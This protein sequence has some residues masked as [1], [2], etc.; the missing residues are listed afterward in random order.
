MVRRGVV[1]IWAVA[2]VILLVLLVCNAEAEDE[3][4]KF[5]VRQ[6]ASG[7]NVIGVL[8]QPIG[9]RLVVEGEAPASHFKQGNELAVSTVNGVALPSAVNIEINRRSL[10]ILSGIRYK[11]EGYETGSFE[12]APDWLPPP[13]PQLVF[14]WRSRFA[15]FRVIEP[16]GLSLDVLDSEDESVREAARC[17]RER[18]A[19]LA[20][21]SATE[22]S[23]LVCIG[24]MMERFPY[25]ASEALERTGSSRRNLKSFQEREG[26]FLI[27]EGNILYAAGLDVLGT[28][29]AVS[30]LQSRLRARDGKVWF[31]FPEW[32]EGGHGVLFEKPAIE[33]R[34]EYLN[35]GYNIPGI[36]PHEWDDA[37]WRQYIDRLVLAKLNRLYLYL[38]NDTYSVYPGSAL[39]KVALNR[40]LHE[41]IRSAIAYA[42]TRGLGVTYMMCPTFFPRDVWEAHPELHA[43]IEYVKHGFP[44]VCPQAPGA[45]DLMKDIARSEMEWFKG[46][47][48][49][50]I[51]FYDPGGC[52][53]EKYGCKSKQ[54]EILARQVVEFSGLFRALNPSAR[55]EYNLWPIWLWEDRMKVQYRRELDERLKTAFGS[56]YRNVTAVGAPDN[57]TTLPLIEKE[58]G[59]R[60]SA[61]LFGTN[62][63]NG[64]VFPLP[65]L[66]WQQ[67][68]AR[69]V[70]ETG[71]DGA[72]G[73][74]LE[75]WTRYPGTFILGQFL[76]NPDI[77]PDAAVRRYSEMLALDMVSGP[78]LTEAI[79]LLERFTQEG[80]SAGLGSQMCARAR[81]MMPPRPSDELA[82]LVAGMEALG[83]IGASLEADTDE[84]L[85]PFV[86]RF[87]EALAN[88]PGYAGWKRDS[89]EVFKRYRDFLRA[90]WRKSP[91]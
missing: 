64:Y 41:R 18:F 21:E 29:H 55:V 58:M 66:A 48:A 9:S 36:T 23:V 78:K 52:W 3:A 63:E 33:T 45:W 8:G 44:A 49:I 2:L 22:P 40:N 12:G 31:D 67:E 86:A 19:E 1:V 14:S 32:K 7:R 15:L 80:A 43:D 68:T 35:I 74:R 26:Y 39:S 84:A 62:P 79:L 85:A 82:D 83:V 54:A 6:F 65:L 20:G 59:Y 27:R 75:A 73:H 24:R 5:S 17:L 42:R 4:P 70:V 16:A 28:V 91:F 38:W 46:A 87:D 57:D 56:E 71:M 10:P 77:E 37:R 11:L 25:L 61:F 13:V 51:W 81:S 53:C 47:D 34:G 50:Q 76:W 88:A 90:G 60:T 89:L 69:R 72:F 30:D